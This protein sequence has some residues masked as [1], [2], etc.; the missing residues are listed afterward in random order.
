MLKNVKQCSRC[1]KT[2]PL[3]KFGKDLSRKDGLTCECRRCRTEM[4]R[5]NRINKTNKPNKPSKKPKR[6]TRCK[7]TKPASEFSPDGSMKR[8]LASRC[9]KC[10][11]KIAKEYYKT[12]VKSKPKPPKNGKKRCGHCGVIRAASEFYFHRASKDGL[13]SDCK[14][15]AKIRMKEYRGAGDN[16]NKEHNRRNNLKKIGMSLEEYDE[17]FDDQGSRCAICRKKQGNLRT[18][19]VDHDHVTGKTRGIICNRCNIGLGCFDDDIDAVRKVLKYLKK[20]A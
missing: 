15:C 5:Q 14:H 12:L 10:M 13:A 8:G 11:C 3:S 6:C 4:N 7:K 1:Q 20:H 18:F 2:K 16:T 19:N 17:M 9:K